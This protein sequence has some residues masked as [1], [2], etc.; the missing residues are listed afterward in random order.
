MS[1]EVLPSS[2]LRHKPSW[3]GDY[4]DDNDSDDDDDYHIDSER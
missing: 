2:I 1:I 4:D 3:F